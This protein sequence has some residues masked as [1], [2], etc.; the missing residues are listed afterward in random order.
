MCFLR[1]DMKLAKKKKLPHRDWIAKDL[2]T[3]KYRLRVIPNKK[4]KQK[5][6]RWKQDKNENCPAFLF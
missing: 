6:Y 1:K 3:D 5:P 4:K 2:H